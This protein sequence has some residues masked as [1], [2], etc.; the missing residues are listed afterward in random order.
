MTDEKDETDE[1][2]ESKDPVLIQFLPNLA[3]FVQ[4]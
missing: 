4:K 2:N 1:I 3:H